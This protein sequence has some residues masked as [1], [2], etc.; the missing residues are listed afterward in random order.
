[1][2]LGIRGRV[3]LIGGGS[4]GIGR[5]SALALAAEGARVAIV[6]RGEEELRVAAA[7]VRDA[8]AQDVAYFSADLGDA[9][10]I[11]AL[12][13]AVEQRLGP[14]EMLVANTGG[15]PTAFFEETDD[16]A[17]HSAFER[18][19]MPIV[20]LVRRVVPGM[21]ERRWGRI[22]TIQSSS[23]KQPIVHHVLSNA[24]RP[25]VAGT[26]KTLSQELGADNILVNTVLPGRIMTERFISIESKWGVPLEERLEKMAAELPLK[27][28]GRPEEVGSVVAFLC[29]EAASYVT[30]VTLQV[31]GGHIRSLA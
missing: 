9:R 22:V 13:D 15:P 8:G 26:F 12:V 14:V 24:F 2:D 10:A 6:A 29:S 7:A 27:R 30:G 31:D 5:A 25:A 19:V 20:R 4:K 28:V 1:M 21:R 18:T 17:W 11:D 23:V 16:D 3:A